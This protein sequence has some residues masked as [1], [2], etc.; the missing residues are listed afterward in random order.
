MTTVSAVIPV[1]NGAL[2]VAEAINGALSQTQ[3]P[4]ECVVI[5]DGSTDATAE[6]VRS[7]G[8]GVTYIRLERGGVSRARNHGAHVAHGE[9][10]AF[11][12]H[13]DVWLPAKLERQIEALRARPEAMMALCAVEMIDAGGT[14]DGVKRLRP[15]ENLITAMLTFD[16]TEIPSCS[17][18]GLV[19]REWL[20]SGGG[21]DPALSTCADWD[22]LVRSLLDGGIAYLDEPLARYRVHDSNMSRNVGSIEHDMRY[23][24]DK[25]FADPRLPAK[26]RGQRRYAY[27]RMYRMLAGSYRDVGDRNAMLRSLVR[28]LSYDP[29]IGFELLTRLRSGSRPSGTALSTYRRHQA[30]RAPR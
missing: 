26:V 4:I 25:A 18:T 27:G 9:L 5:D 11:L 10:V 2:Y 19:R 30:P 3:P 21:F 13:D 24:F 7:F 20:L 1:H 17:S 8:T 6:V 12:D 16:G 28:S 15:R 23:A 14:P 29:A 22:L